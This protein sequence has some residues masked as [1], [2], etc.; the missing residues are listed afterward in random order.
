[1]QIKEHFLL[2]IK[3][4]KAIY[5]P[6][7]LIY[8][9]YGLSGFTSIA[10][11]FWLKEKLSISALE[12]SQIAFW[13]T[14]PWSLKIALSQIIDNL[15]IL[16]DNRRIY[17]FIGAL[18]QIL[19]NVILLG[20][21]Q[22]HAW[23]HWFG[24]LYAQ[25]VW[26]TLLL[27]SGMV[28]QD[29]VADVMCVE[30]AHSESEIKIIQLLGRIAFMLGALCSNQIGGYL[31]EKY[32]FTDIIHYE[33]FA[34][35]LTML[36]IIS[37]PKLNIKTSVWDYK[38]VL[39]G[40]I[41]MLCTAF[42]TYNDYTYGQEIIVLLSLIA[43]SKLLD[44][45]LVDI[46]I[47]KKIYSIG[48]LLFMTRIDPVLGAGIEWW[49]I[50]ILHFNPLFFAYTEQLSIVCGLLGTWLLST[51]V[52]KGEVVKIVLLIKSLECLLSFPYIGMAY[53]LHVWTME[54]FG[55]GAKSIALISIIIES[56][57]NQ[58][59]LI[60]ALSIAAIYAPNRNQTTWL[61]LVACMLNLPLSINV[62]I[63][64]WLNHFFVVERGEYM[65]I[66]CLLTAKL[67]ISVLACCIGLLGYYKIR[68]SKQL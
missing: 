35:L 40:V 46:N 54:H 12:L 27:S 45:N 37:R 8:F 31:A 20:I 61:A 25:L 10:Q 4:M 67:C 49:Q 60:L 19:G 62:I 48:F 33:F 53:G 47:K 7:L 52:V 34:P 16:H 21:A 13:A 29:L 50:D 28:L 30:I 41:I 66:G 18:L 51:W 56:P 38:I 22:Q 68:G 11:M 14:I 55:F 6:M 5:L 17:I 63:G 64:K 1:M 26:V 24:N 3:S 9:C 44:A 59:L 32:S 15:R 39:T 42:F 23:L 36:A 57:F 43:I 2:P 58:L 65:H